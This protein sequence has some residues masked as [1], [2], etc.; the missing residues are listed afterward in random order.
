M[1]AGKEAAGESPPEE[2]VEVLSLR[3]RDYLTD[4]GR[5]AVMPPLKFSQ[6]ADP[7]LGA[8][9][10]ARLPE[11]VDHPHAARASRER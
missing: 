7:G 8:G 1:L 6:P 2:D 9:L 3:W 5:A 4:P 10:M 11:L